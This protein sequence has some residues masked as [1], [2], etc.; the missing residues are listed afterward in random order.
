MRQKTNLNTVNQYP[1]GTSIYMEGDLI[2]SIALVIKGR[3]LVHHEG[4]K[5][6]M[7]PGSFL[8]VSDILHGKHQSTYT[9]L[10]DLMV[11]VFTINQKEQLENIMSINSDYNGFIIMSMNIIISELSKTYQEILKQGHALYDF[12]SDQY[13][14]YYESATRLGYTARRP[15]WVDDLGEFDSYIELDLDKISYYKEST[16]VPIDVVKAYYSYSDIITRYQVEE[17]IE[18]ISQLNDILKEYAKKLIFMSGCLVDESATC[19]FGLIAEYAIEIVNGGGNSSEIMDNMDAIIEKIN[20]IKAFCDSRLGSNIDINRKRMEEA[21]HLVISGTKD[22]DMSAE[23][24]LKYSI[25]D[26]ERVME[27]LSGSYQKILS[28]SGIDDKR[29]QNMQDIMLDFVNLKDRL[30]VD[31]NARRI[32]KQLTQEHYD[33]YKAV[34]LKAYND[35]EVPRI[36]DM[37]LKYG[38]ADERLLTN[39]QLLSLYFLKD[40]E[41]PDDIN[42]YNIKEWLTLIY[43]G[44]KEPS[45]NEFDQE[46]YETLLSLKKKGKLTDKDI[47]DLNNNKDYKLEYEIQNMFLYNNRT[48]S[49]QISIFVPVLHKDLYLS[50]PDKSYITPNKVMKELERLLEIDYSIF[51]REVMLVDKESNIEKEYIIKRVCPDIILMPTVGSNGVMWQDITMKRRGSPG[52]FLFPIFCEANLF[53]NIVMVC[54]RFRWEICRTIEGVAWN[55]IKNKSLTSEYSDYLQFYRRNREL[56]EERKGKI[57]LQIQKGRSNSREIFVIDYKSWINYESKGAIKLNKFVRELMATYVPF[58]KRI[59]DQL[60]GQPIFDE[61]YVR[62]NKNRLKKIRETEG[63]HRLLHKENIKPTKEMED[64]LNYYKES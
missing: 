5:Y 19:L 45:K 10:E 32:R 25:K 34:F 21:Y 2:S 54:G 46:Y 22:K 63:R 24:Y 37:Y 43:E 1:K 18:V 27:E 12:L 8:A 41:K 53:T 29:A 16:T 58:S 3:V 55:D 60:T 6:I 62:F 44:N 11:Y 52:R 4:A 50:Q 49:G 30:S 9:A 42:I 31:D 40:E 57:K 36:I 51:D 33:L 23:T 64:T 13:K 61:A 28:Y 38:Y 14:L 47:K 56:S 48:T 39:E 17:Q 20:S 59:R 15:N 7:V 35:K 26:A